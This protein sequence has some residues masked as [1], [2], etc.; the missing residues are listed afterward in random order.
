MGMW[1]RSGWVEVVGVHVL[2]LFF[3]DL[4]YLGWYG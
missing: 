4:G 2:A 3:G 1:C